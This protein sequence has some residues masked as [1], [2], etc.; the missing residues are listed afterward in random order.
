MQSSSA[1]ASAPS[2]A[3][4]A[5]HPGVSDP[6]Y[7]ER[8]AA[9]AETGA[10]YRSGDP[11]PDVEYSEGEH[12]LWATVI[13]EL[14]AKHDRYAARVARAGV[15][16]LALP[17]DRVPQL[18]EVS[19]RL[20]AL[21][22]FRVEPVPGL[23]PTE[24]FY[25]ALADRCFLSTQYMRHTSVPFYTPEP[26][27]V[28]EVAGHCSLLAHPL[29]ADLHH[30]AGQAS[31]RARTADELEAFSRVFWFTLEFGVVREDGELRCYGAG[32][33]SSFGEIETFRDAEIRPFD[34]DAMSHTEYDIT[35]YQPVLF[36]AEGIEEMA[37]CLHAWFLR[38]GTASE[39][40]SR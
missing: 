36:A 21:T 31:R 7:R 28:H 32:L 27:I 12:A 30:A 15:A 18:R 6:A 20:R 14:G 17:T 1:V 4:P 38:F 40:A 39:R 26:D 37:S 9:I 33:L 34:I 22:G 24:R 11:V 16:A 8:R 13:G 35:R 10:A 2:F 23:V 29:F 3:L 19:Q 5:D 25:G